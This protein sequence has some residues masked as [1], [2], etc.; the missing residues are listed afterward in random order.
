MRTN[1]N[2]IRKG[3]VIFMPG[4]LLRRLGSPMDGVDV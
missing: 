2:A 4:R 3:G 1:G